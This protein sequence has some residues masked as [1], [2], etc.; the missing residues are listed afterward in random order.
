MDLCRDGIGSVRLAQCGV[1]V[2]DNQVNRVVDASTLD[3]NSSFDTD[4]CII[5]AGAAG[6]T[7]AMELCDSKIKVLLL[8]SGGL[9]SESETQSL[10]QGESTGRPYYPLEAARLRYFGGTTNHWSGWCAPLDPLDFVQRDWIPH[11]GWP[12]DYQDLEPWYWRAHQ[13]CQL[14]PFQFEAEYW[15]EQTGLRRLPLSRET[16]A[17]KILQFSPPTRF[18]TVYRDKIIGASNITLW[19]H[20]NV[21]NIQSNPAASRATGVEVTTLNKKK[22]LVRA[23]AFVLACGGMENPRILLL[24]NHVNEQGLGNHYGVVGRYFMEHPHLFTSTVLLPKGFNVDFY[25]LEWP[26]EPSIRKP[27]VPLFGITPAVQRAQKIANYSSILWPSE[28]PQGDQPTQSRQLHTRI[29]QVPNPESRITLAHDDRDLLGQPKIRFHWQLTQLDKKT[30]RIAEQLLANQLGRTQVGRLQMPDWLVSHNDEWSDTMSGG[31]HHMGTTRMSDDPRTGV[32]DANCK[33]HG[34][35]NLYV[36][37]SSVFSTAG[38]AN[39]TMTIVALAA[40]LASHIRE[41]A[42]S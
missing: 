40:R 26:N 4:L 22:L 3:D 21:T 19:T 11:S 28:S 13:I 15:E 14:G 17:T 9:E 42:L 6:I 30:I 36:A 16:V 31:P 12:I 5:G 10:Y 32:V 20:A 35:D 29:E 37:G 39:P 34:I 24:S 25:E 38:T 1:H 23:K 7:V 2:N 8:E 41:N 18:G 27:F 33:I